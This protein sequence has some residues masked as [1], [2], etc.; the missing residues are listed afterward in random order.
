MARHPDDANLHAPALSIEHKFWR[1]Y[2]RVVS[3]SATMTD[4]IGGNYFNGVMTTMDAKYNYEE[5]SGGARAPPFRFR[6]R[7]SR[8]A[9]PT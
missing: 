7:I 9:T 2:K 6:A 3:C 4:I 5:A 1:A 8:P